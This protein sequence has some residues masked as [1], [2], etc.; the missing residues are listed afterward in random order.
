MNSGAQ[1]GIESTDQIADAEIAM[2]FNILAALCGAVS[3]VTLP[4][5]AP[6]DTSASA[7]F[8]KAPVRFDPD[9]AA[10]AFS[11]T[12]LDCVPPGADAGLRR[13]LAE[14]VGE[15]SRLAR[16]TTSDEVRRILRNGLHEEKD[17]C[18]AKIAGLLALHPRTLKRRLQQEGTAF[19]RIADEVRF[20]TARQLLGALK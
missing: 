14:R 12:L 9:V 8:F 6:S 2:A 11:T 4:R 7:R 15:L 19:K 13:I 18:L 5:S 17:G 1:P 20:E 3:E 10:L 16:Q